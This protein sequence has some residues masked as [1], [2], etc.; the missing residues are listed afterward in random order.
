MDVISDIIAVSSTRHG[1]ACRRWSE[2]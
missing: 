1:T 2:A